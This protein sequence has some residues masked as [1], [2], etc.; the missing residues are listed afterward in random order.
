VIVTGNAPAFAGWVVLMAA[1]AVSC[2]LQARKTTNPIWRIGWVGLLL[3]SL[4]WLVGGLLGFRSA[5]QFT[6]LS[7]V[8][9]A[10]AAVSALILL[11]ALT[12]PKRR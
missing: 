9:T 11:G 7:R 10:I 2:F 1:A 5:G 6:I 12:I 4:T 3:A 8:G